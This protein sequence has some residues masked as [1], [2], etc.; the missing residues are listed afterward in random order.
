MRILVAHNSYQQVGGEDHAV[1]AEIA[2]LNAH[3]HEVVPY[4]LSNN[5]VEGMSR[6][7]LG[8]RTI[9]SRSA[10]L[11]VRRLCRTHRPDVVHFHNTLPLISPAA[12][13]AA[14]AERVPVVQTLHNFRVCCVNSLLFRQGHLCE[15]CLGRSA[16]WRGVLHNCYRGSR[17][18][19]A[20]I[21]AMV[22]VHRALG[23]W[24]DAVDAY[25]ALSE[26]SRR[27]FVQGGLPPE[28]IAVKP[29]FVYPDPGPGTGAGG[30][31]LFVG[32]LSGE[33]GV[34][35]LLEAWR[36]LDGGPPLKIVGDGALAAQV[37]P[38][39]R[40]GTAE[41]LREL[42]HEAVYRL[43]GA[44]AFV[45]LP[46]QCYENFPLVV[47][48]AFAKGTPVIVSRLGAMAE[49]VEDG[50]TGLHFRPGDPADLATKVRALVADPA[51]L[52]RM[53]AAARETFERKFT[54][55]VNH[56]AMMAIYARACAKGVASGGPELQTC[57]PVLEE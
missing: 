10:F 47:I 14:R 57:A 7:A 49:I 28:R 4:R 2:M 33:K 31:G 18:A 27:K 13:Y 51:A 16:P 41:W 35:V 45:V 23:T 21:T 15:E 38:A 5:A 40:A 17:A 29:N 36:R 50:R 54:A 37:E 46:S 26:S 12:Y 20:A 19:G 34:P 30:Y 43:V 1:A 52:A 53:R 32:R 3:G 44:A 22:A 39:L 9:W 48:E 25:I 6:L 55:A 11:D 24:R 56:Q 42:P 8:A